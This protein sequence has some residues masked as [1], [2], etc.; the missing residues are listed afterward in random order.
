MR[1]SERRGDVCEMLVKRD[2]SLDRDRAGERDRRRED[3]VG[4][5]V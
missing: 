3:G 5:E 4:A 2:V 1:G